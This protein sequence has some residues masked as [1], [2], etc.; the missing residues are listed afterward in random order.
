MTGRTLRIG[1]RRSRLAMWQSE[2][3]ARLLREL[4]PGLKVDIVPVRTLG[5]RDRDS[6]LAGMGRTGV[7]T[8]EIEDAL[9][10]GRCDLAVHSLK[11]LPTAL[12]PGLSLAAI[13]ERA[14]VR[15]AWICGAGLGLD[16]AP[17]GATVGTSS[18]RRRS[19]LLHRRPDLKM[20]ELRGNVPSRL[21]AAGAPVEEGGTPKTRVDATILAY[22]GLKRLGLERY[23]SEILEPETMLPA[24]GQGAVAVEIR[25]D[26]AGTAELLLPLDHGPT[27]LA[28][29]AERGFLE[30]L[31]G[32]CS[33]PVGALATVAGRQIHLRGVVAGAEGRRRLT[34][35]T[36]GDD[37]LR[38]GQE[39]ARELVDRGAGEI[40]ERLRG[41][42]PGENG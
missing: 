34:G 5:D 16:E 18:L 21:R 26:D 42:A 37:P 41:A 12:T 17:E 4:H 9:F 10:D 11:D 22:A 2:W 39:L 30:A 31:G 25:A 38:L 15:D 29:A 24:P 23:A 32:G 27:R 28:T 14:D 6:S 33:V 40:L 8:K 19:Q 3:A 7:F 20:T 35:E 13:L 1:T 36:T